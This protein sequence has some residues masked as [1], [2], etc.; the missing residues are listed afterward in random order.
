MAL[1]WIGEISLLQTRV[2]LYP[3]S[4]YFSPFPDQRAQEQEIDHFNH[5]PDLGFTNWNNMA[6][7]AT[8]L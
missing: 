4:H 7:E 3:D 1:L 6:I 5:Y 8:K 2:A